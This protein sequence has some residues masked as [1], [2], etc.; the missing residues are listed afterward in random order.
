MVTKVAMQVCH[1]IQPYLQ[2]EKA[3]YVDLISDLFATRIADL[4]E[5]PVPF[6]DS[7]V[8][9]NRHLHVEI[10]RLYSIGKHEDFFAG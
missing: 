5:C 4:H 7:T 8:S 6:V 10:W 1:K 9:V 2:I 3:R